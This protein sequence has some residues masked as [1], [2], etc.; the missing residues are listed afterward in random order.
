MGKGSRP[1]VQRLQVLT[2]QSMVVW[3]W[4]WGHV[5]CSREWWAGVGEHL[6]ALVLYKASLTRVQVP[7]LH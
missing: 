5:L 2:V 4:Q 7:H 6:W 3:E 1:G